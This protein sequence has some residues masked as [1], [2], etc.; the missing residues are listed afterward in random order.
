MQ[1][2]VSQFELWDGLF[3]FGEIELKTTLVLANL[4]KLYSAN[5]HFGGV[6]FLCLCKYR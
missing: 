2:A 3:R 1:E 5:S 6:K 4:I